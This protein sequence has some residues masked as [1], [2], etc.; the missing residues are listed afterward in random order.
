MAIGNPIGKRRRHLEAVMFNLFAK[1]DPGAIAAGVPRSPKWP[2]VRAAHLK[3]HPACEACGQR[4][5]L[6][7]HHIEPFHLRPELELD[8]TNLVTLCGVPC[9]IVHGHFMNWSLFNRTVV[10]D[11]RTYRAKLEAAK[12]AG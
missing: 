10:A 7:V 1:P 6:E 8:P 5:A 9:H 11:V 4:D 2:A 12:K 3:A